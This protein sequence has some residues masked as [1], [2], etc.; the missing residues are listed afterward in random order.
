MY[1]IHASRYV[2]GRECPVYDVHK[3][4]VARGI[5]GR[6]RTHDFDLAFLCMFRRRFW[7]EYTPGIVRFVCYCVAAFREFDKLFWGLRGWKVCFG[8]P[9]SV[10]LSICL[11]SVV[12]GIRGTVGP[13]LGDRWPCLQMFQLHSFAYPHS[14][15]YLMLLPSLLIVCCF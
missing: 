9:C 8:C 7:S 2:A 6:W 12:A 14:F 4:T 13:S 5:D 3:H 10:H 1:G 11:T 15:H